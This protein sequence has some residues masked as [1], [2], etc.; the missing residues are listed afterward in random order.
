MRFEHAGAR[1]S[2]VGSI[3]TVITKRWSADESD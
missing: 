1:L 2:V 3:F